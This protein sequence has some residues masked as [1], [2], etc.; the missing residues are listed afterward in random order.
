MELTADKD[1]Y[2]MQNQGNAKTPPV[3][4]LDALARSTGW[5]EKETK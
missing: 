4:L 1:K 2:P 3:A 5:S